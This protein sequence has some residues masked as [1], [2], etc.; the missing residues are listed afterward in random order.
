M[1]KGE[2]KKGLNFKEKRE[3]FIRFLD[4]KENRTM[5]LATSCNNRVMAR[6][7]LVASHGLDLYFFTWGHSR[8]CRQI[9]KN[10]RVAL[11]KDRV[12]IEGVAEI[13]GVS[14]TSAIKNIQI[15]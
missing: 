14:L 8:K 9:R 2:G 12:Q 15:L 10:S 7:V 13:L 6:N 5:V 4:A 11:C 3:E 1:S